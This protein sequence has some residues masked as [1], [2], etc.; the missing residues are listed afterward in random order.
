MRCSGFEAFQESTSAIAPPLASDLEQ[1][2]NDF[3]T[4]SEPT[5]NQSA[6]DWDSDLV[7]T[8][9]P[10]SS[11]QPDSD[12]KGSSSDD[13]HTP[14]ELT[15]DEWSS[16]LPLSP[17]PPVPHATLGP[18]VVDFPDGF[19][20]TAKTRV[21]HIELV[22][23]IPSQFPIPEELTA[24]IVC[25]DTLDA[26]DK[27]KTIDAILKD[28]APHS[29]SGST[30]SR[31]EPDAFVIGS[32]FGLDPSVRVACR[33][34]EAKCGG[35][36]ACE[37]LDAAFLNAPRRFPDP[38]Y[39]QTLIEAEMRTRELQDTS[40]VGQVLTFERSL[41]SFS[42]KAILA[43]GSSCNGTALMVRAKKRIRNKDY[44]IVC[45]Q[46]DKPCAQG[47]GRHTVL[48]I[49]NHIDEDILFKVLNHQPIVE[50]HDAGELCTRVMSGRQGFR[51]KAVCPYN[52]MKDGLSFK[53]KIIALTCKAIYHAYCPWED[54]FPDLSHTAVVIP[55][56]T[57]HMHPPPPE[58]KI[59]QTVARLY[60]EC[61]RKLG[62]SAT[63]AR[64]DRAPTTIALLGTTPAL[65]HPALANRDIRLRLIQRVKEELNGP[66]HTGDALPPAERYLQSSIIRDGRT[67]I[68]GIYPELIKNI[69][70]VRTL[71]CD[72]TF[73]PV[74]GSMQ[75]FEVNAWLT[76]INEAVTL[77]RVWM[78]AHDRTIFKQVWEELRRLVTVLIGRPL[79]FKGLH[80]RGT[81]LGLNADMEVAPLLGFAEAFLP[82]IDREELRGVITNA[83]TLLPFVLRL[84]YTHIF[85]GVPEAPHLSKD[86]HDRIKGFVHLET[87]QAVEDFKLWIANVPDPDGTIARWWKQK[88][89]HF[90]LLP[91]K[92]QCLSR[93]PLNDW[94]TMSATTNLGEAQHARNNAET[95]T[96][97]GIIESFKKYAE[98]DARRAAEINVKLA[99]GNLN[100]NQNELVHRYAS[101]NRRHAAAADKGM[102]AR[103]ADERVIALR[104]AKVQVEVELKQAVAESKLTTDQSNSSGRVP[105]RR[106]SKGKKVEKIGHGTSNVEHVPRRSPGRV[107]APSHSAE[108][109]RVD[110]Q[111]D[112]HDVQREKEGQTL[113]T[114]DEASG[115]RRLRSHGADVSFTTSTRDTAPSTAKRKLTSTAAAPAPKPKRR[116]AGDPLAGWAIEL[117][118]GDKTTAVSPREYAEKEPEEF[119][120][121][122]PQYVKFL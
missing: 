18:G 66:E 112:E 106:P 4:F 32:L 12:I 111:E 122:Y 41:Q 27:R 11:L 53:A 21:F 29:Y 109:A 79:L 2:E 99:T 23:G 89:M 60:M 57:P 14:C 107:V 68:F 58:N 86:D 78:E 82:T 94:H 24:F 117:V 37:S 98:Y 33:R 75:I 43:D 55:T 50:N 93:I 44:V 16:V 80:V 34:V 74:A 5:S 40:T 8:Y 95:G 101:S 25:V 62:S 70:R 67:V 91:A 30:G 69:H 19:P 52:H 120:A 48:A 108:E 17:L 51:G 87:P 47:S 9:F 22:N 83:G 26:E 36:V 31:R 114:G 121:Q 73:K 39:R 45:S 64:V 97:M 88:L 119:A 59:N 1:H 92:I 35:V 3:E 49:L 15:P 13:G 6:L 61:A 96:Q 115:P 100:N 81:I 46:Q 118:P 76:A 71:D 110:H 28:C 54:R 20:I 72:T 102:R 105:A 38:L 113:Q 56:L 84:C 77:G 7:G 42:C 65:F 103:D 90:W 116:K 63:P 85:R 10:E 104:Q